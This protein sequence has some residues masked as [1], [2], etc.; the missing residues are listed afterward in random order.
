MNSSHNTIDYVVTKKAS[1]LNLLGRILLV[2]LYAA[3]GIGIFV[4]AYTVADIIG[5]VAGGVMAPILMYILFSLTWRHVSYEYKY[6]IYTPTANLNQVPHTVIELARMKRN[7][8]KETVPHVIYVREMRDAELIAP[9]IPENESKYAS[10]DVKKVIDFRSK[11]S[12]KKDCY[13][14]RFSEKDG[15]KTVVIVEA[16]NKIVD[17]FKY[18]NKDVTEVMELSR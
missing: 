18:H 1:G 3:V 11:P 16:V 14:L 6:Q 9:Y 2:L 7:N 10:S 8:K 17:A 4:L 13:F 5:I 12:V 15:S